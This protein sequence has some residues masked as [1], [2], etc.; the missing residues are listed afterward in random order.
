MDEEARGSR[1]CTRVAR[2]SAPLSCGRRSSPCCAASSAK[3]SRS[4]PLNNSSES[5]AAVLRLRLRSALGL[6]ALLGGRSA[7]C[8]RYP[9]ARSEA[10]DSSSSVI[11]SSGYVSVTAS[12]SSS[13]S[14]PVA[15]DALA[16][17]ATLR[18]AALAAATAASARASSSSSV[19]LIS[20]TLREPDEPCGRARRG[21]ALMAAP[22]PEA[23][24]L[25]ARSAALYRRWRMMA[26][27]YSS[28]SSLAPS[29]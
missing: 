6:R 23:A 11:V 1:P 21:A 2:R 25:P 10:R 24:L 29:S 15:A 8:T 4:S 18:A 14:L 22:A 26:G 12:S 7:G 9:S 20:S 13:S 5:S 17:L 16:A 28:S 27:T 3:P 19:R